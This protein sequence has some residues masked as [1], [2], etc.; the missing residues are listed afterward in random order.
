VAFEPTHQH[1]KTKASFASRNKA[2]LHAAPPTSRPVTTF[3]LRVK[4]K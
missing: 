3:Y 1:S 4:A 2:P